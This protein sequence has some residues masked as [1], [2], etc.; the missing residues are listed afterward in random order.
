[1]RNQ[2]IGKVLIA[3]GGGGFDLTFE[4]GG[5]FVF[6]STQLLRG[7]TVFFGPQQFLIEG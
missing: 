6:R 4:Q 3:P 2:R 5:N 1:M 7:K